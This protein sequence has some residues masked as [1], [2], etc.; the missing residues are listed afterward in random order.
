M[1]S[2]L[3]C[4]L[5]STIFGCCLHP[6]SVAQLQDTAIGVCN[7][8]KAEVVI[9]VEWCGIGWYVCTGESRLWLDRVIFMCWRVC[10]WICFSIEMSNFPPT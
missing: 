4:I 3:L 9:S 1:Y 5:S 2:L 10:K 7:L 6:S 8:W